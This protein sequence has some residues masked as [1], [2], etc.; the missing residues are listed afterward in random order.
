MRSPYQIIGVPED[1]SLPEIKSAYRQ[2]AKALHPDKNGGSSTLMAELNSA[3]EEIE[4]NRSL[5]P[6]RQYVIYQNFS[7][8]EAYLGTT[9]KIVV[10]NTTYM[11]HVQP[12][13]ENGQTLWVDSTA[14]RVICTVMNDDKF[15][16]VGN[17]LV[18]YYSINPLDAMLGGSR[19]IDVF[20]NKISI[21]IPAGIQFGDIIRI[22]GLGFK[23][24]DILIE[25]GIRIP[26]CPEEAREALLAIRQQYFN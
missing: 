15:R 20:G 8:A 22:P 3:Y 13:V 23:G 1:A 2:K 25:V 16:R 9:R 4:R 17:D 7:L 26:S 19:T 18:F 6:A 24:G 14:I 11:L 5:V 21:Y 12:G 10:A